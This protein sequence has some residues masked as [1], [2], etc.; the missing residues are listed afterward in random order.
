LPTITCTNGGPTAVV[1]FAKPSEADQ[2]Q[3]ELL[4]ALA[5]T[6]VVVFL[7]L[8]VHG[9][10]FTPLFPRRVRQHLAFAVL[11]DQDIP[12][13]IDPRII[14]VDATPQAAVDLLKL[15]RI[16][17]IRQQQILLTATATV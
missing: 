10:L 9:R 6:E 1:S 11:P 13:S 14:I 15:G 3:R 4:S 16:G 12:A 7:G 2:Q 5:Q 8:F 17:Q